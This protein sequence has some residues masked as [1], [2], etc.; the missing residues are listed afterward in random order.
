MNFLRYLLFPFSVLYG[1]IMSVRNFLYRTNVFQ[2]RSYPI[3]IISVGNLNTGGTGKSPM[4]ELLVKTLKD[5]HQ[6]ATLSRGY[7]RTTEGFL[8]VQ[9]YHLSSEVGDEPL[10]FKI[11]FPEITVA[12]DANRQRGISELLKKHPQLDLILLDD[13]FQHRKVK[14]NLSILLTTYGDLYT[15]DFMLPTG[16]LREFQTGASRADVIIVTKCPGNLAVE[17]QSRIKKQLKPG[18]TQ[19]LLFSTILYSEFVKNATEHEKLAGFDD[20]TLVTGIANPKPLVNHLKSLDKNFE[21]IQ[22]ADHHEFS[23]AD[24]KM[25]QKKPKLLTTQKDYVRL[26][27]KL[28]SGKLF[29]IPIETQILNE[30]GFLEKYL[31]DRLF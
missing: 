6:I 26:K 8:E 27:S 29:Y 1:C 3:S 10:Q 18:V 31:E 22:F 30:P 9:P 13:A 7:K 23:E 21:H 16:N 12:V 28:E 25:L 20:F 17:E 19:K 14:P 4:I 15:K 11:N 5:K 2:S 24:L